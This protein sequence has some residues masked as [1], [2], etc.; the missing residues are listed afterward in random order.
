M[1]TYTGGDRSK[2]KHASGM[3]L[4]AA[5]AALSQK[6]MVALGGS[7]VPSKTSSLNARR[8][9]GNGASSL[10]THISKK[11]AIEQAKHQN[12]T[13]QEKYEELESKYNEL[14]EQ[15]EHKRG[16]GSSASAGQQ[17]SVRVPARENQL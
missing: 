7:S 5:T 16:D 4:S 1:R 15:L 12:K 8:A 9:S 3:D 11:A 14:L 2:A 6:Q 17:P 13:I 10:A